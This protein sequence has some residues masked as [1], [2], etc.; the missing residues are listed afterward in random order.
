ME[1]D[2]H[3]STQT[4]VDVTNV[5]A[6]Q[7][8]NQEIHGSSSLVEKR[9]EWTEDI[10][11]NACPTILLGVVRQITDLWSQRLRISS[12]LDPAKLVC[13]FVPP[14]IKKNALPR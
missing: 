12:T 10:I 11:S 9:K 6:A 3:A 5:C 2:I 1:T 13:E 8:P 4:G 14:R 7:G